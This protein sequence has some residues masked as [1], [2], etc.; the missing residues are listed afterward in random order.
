MLRPKW[1]TPDESVLL[2]TPRFPSEEPWTCTG[3]TLKA[4]A[5]YRPDQCGRGNK[6]YGARPISFQP[7]GRPSVQWGCQRNSTGQQCT[8]WHHFLPLTRSPN[9]AS[10][11]AFF[12]CSTAAILSPLQVSTYS[13]WRPAQL[14]TNS[15]EM[16][17]LSS[18]LLIERLW[19]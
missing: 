5:V 1:W 14:D 6:Q 3:Q 2:E 17:N 8:A 9:P 12:R 15:M 4:D 7:V 19:D 16:F 13:N 11:P 18:C 10:P